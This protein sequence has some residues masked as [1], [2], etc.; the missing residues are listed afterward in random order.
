DKAADYI[1]IKDKI[2]KLLLN[3]KINEPS[4]QEKR[5]FVHYLLLSFEEGFG[6]ILSIP[7][8]LSKIRTNAVYANIWRINWVFTRLTL[9]QG[10]TF[11][12]EMHLIE[13]FDSLFGT[14][15]DVDKII[16]HIKA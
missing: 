12:S 5:S 2:K 9:T 11:A 10:L 13:Q 16:A 6:E 7:F 1:K 14:H 15:T 3:E 4:T 8:H